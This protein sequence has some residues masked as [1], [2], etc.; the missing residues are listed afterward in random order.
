MFSTKKACGTAPAR[1][2]QAT[3]SN[4]TRMG[5]SYASQ[6]LLQLFSVSVDAFRCATCFLPRL[7]ASRSVTGPVTL[8]TRASI[9]VLT[10]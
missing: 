7:A 4:R 9:S 6:L 5:Q 1:P 8:T 3:A 10:K 2:D